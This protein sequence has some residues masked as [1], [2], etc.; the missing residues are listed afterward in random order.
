MKSNK[1]I[2]NI[3]KINYMKNIIKKSISVLVFVGIFGFLTNVSFAAPTP[4]IVS[5]TATVTTNS[6]TLDGVV[7]PNGDDTTAWFETPSAGPFQTQSIGNGSSDTSMFSYNLTGLSPNTTYTFRI[8]ASNVNGGP[9]SGNWI[10]FTTNAAPV[11]PTPTIVSGIATNISSTSATLNGVV[12]PNGDAT[13]A[14][15]ETPSAGPFQTQSIGNG[16]SDTSLFTYDLKGLK[17][18]TNYT[19]RIGASNINGGP[20]SGSWI[21]FTTGVAPT[22][23]APTIVSGVATNITST[24]A[25]L[26]GIVNPNG[27]NTTAWFETPSAGPFQTQSIGKANTDTALFSYNLT[28]LKPSTNYTFRIGASNINGGPTSGSWI[29]F[30]TGALAANPAPTIISATVTGITT[31]SVTLNGI[32]NPNGDNTTAWFETPSAGPF[33]TQ[34]IGNANT[35]TTLLTYNLTGLSPNTTYTFR[36]GASNVNGGPTSGNWISFTTNNIGGGGGA[37]GAGPTISSISPSFVTAGAG[38]TLVTITGT[39]F[40]SG[41]SSALF[42][43]TARTTNFINGTTISIALTAN[44]VLSQGTG[45]I[46]ISNGACTSGSAIFTIN[47]IGGGNGGGGNGGGGNGTNSTPGTTN[48]VTSATSNKPTTTVQA[49]QQ[50]GTTAKLNG[51]FVNQKGLPAQAYFQY[52]KTLAMNQTTPKKDIGT[53]TLINFS[54]TATNLEPN[55]IYYFRSVV[56]SGGINYLGDVFVFRTSNDVKTNNNNIIDSPIIDTTN[57]SNNS[58]IDYSS[59]TTAK[60]TITNTDNK[61]NVGD[62]VTYS[63]RFENITNK[64]L[65]NIKL[66]VQLPKEIDLNS[67]GNVDENNTVTFNIEDLIP[68]EIKTITVKGKVNDTA[69]SQNVLTTTAIASYNV[70]GSSLKKDEISSVVN[71]MVDSKL[72]LGA[73]SFLGLG[74]LPKWAG[75]TSLGIIILGLGTLGIRFYKK[76]SLKK[77]GVIESK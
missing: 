70:S 71:Y 16:N 56:I 18:S 69:S 25:T 34:S 17:P 22:S 6:A 4:T 1:Y 57:N 37:C 9:T 28:G 49:T 41:T 60:L 3:I 46:T 44:D 66:A 59:I 77:K 32:V 51:V 76:Y 8:G 50:T 27:D 26:D 58:P 73:S 31:T 67:L 74:F 48:N 72:G 42:N 75:I 5:G 45:N 20:T 30:T 47:A 35:N 61:L 52:G 39:N 15:F 62:I 24:S 21:S 11:S 12:N 19:F 38:A 10:S 29:S 33:Q 14:W 53:A 68:N 43:G 55:T 40:V 54:S 36:I 64:K 63:I 7:N 13:T 23:P 2:R 65:E